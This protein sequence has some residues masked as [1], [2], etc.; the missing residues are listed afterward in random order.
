M[1]ESD[2]FVTRVHLKTDTDDRQGLIDYCLHSRE[3]HGT[4]YIAVGWSCVYELEDGTS[5]KPDSADAFF[6]LYDQWK[7]RYGKRA[8]H[9]INVFRETLPGD[10]FWTRDLDGCYWIC[11]ATGTALPLLN[12]ELDIGIA[13]PVDAYRIGHEVPGQIRASFNR[14]RGGTSESFH[15]K[16]IVEYSKHVYNQ[17]SGTQIYTVEKQT[18]ST[19]LI[20]NLP[21]LELEELVITYLQLEK[22]LYVLSNSIANKSTSIKVECE[23]LS[24]TNPGERAVVQVKGGSKHTLYA[25]EFQSLVDAGTTVYPKAPVVILDV[26]SPLVVEITNE[27]LQAF[28]AANKQLLPHSITRW[29]N[30]FA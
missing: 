9:V 11:R 20:S 2:I 24:R 13:V 26:A 23:L 4:D 8:D 7:S 30:L 10:L 29:E 18:T 5:A 6:A 22:D 19:D 1:S 14:P 25:S 28:Y 3:E 12:E 27:Q 21:A 16:M 15:D 17:C